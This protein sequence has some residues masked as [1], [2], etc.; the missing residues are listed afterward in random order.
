MKKSNSS[1]RG[2]KPAPGKNGVKNS[3]SN[4]N[5]MLKEFFLESLKDIYW[6]EKHLVKSLPK[7]EKAATTTTLKEVISEHTKITEEQVK[8][9][10]QVFEMMGEKPQTKK[11]EAMEGLTKEGETVI[12]ETERGSFTRDVG[13]IVA[14]QKVEHYEIATYGGLVQIARTLGED[15]VA[16]LLEETLKEEKEADQILTN[17]AEEQINE[18][19]LAEQQGEEV[20][21]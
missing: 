14:S 12:E 13:L 5:A 1:Q 11:C 7:M 3:N 8:R 10:E 4:S 16:D 15:D 9:L 6:A 17:L 18:E 2:S 20:G 19:A 21:E